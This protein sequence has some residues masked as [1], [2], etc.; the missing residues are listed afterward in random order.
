MVCFAGH[1]IQKKPG[2]PLQPRPCS[3]AGVRRGGVRVVGCP[4]YGG[5]GVGRS[6]VPHR[7]TGPGPL[8]PL[9]YCSFPLYGSG[10]PT[11]RVRGSHCT[12]LGANMVHFWVLKWS[13]SGSK[14]PI[15][16]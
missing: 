6:V 15:L 10:V 9:F 12:G 5:T 1:C 11:V 2:E 13:I 7:G 8:F 4:G 16:G 3:S 14:W